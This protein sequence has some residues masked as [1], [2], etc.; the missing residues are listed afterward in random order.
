[1]GKF[2]L[3]FSKEGG[4]MGERREEGCL[5]DGVE[6]VVPTAAKCEGRGRGR[7]LYQFL[8]KT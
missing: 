7:R 2:L 4:E 3:A 8:V 6:S 5:S 1:M